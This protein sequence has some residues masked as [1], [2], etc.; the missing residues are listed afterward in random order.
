VTPGFRVVSARA[1]AGLSDSASQEALARDAV[2]QALLEGVTSVTLPAAARTQALEEASAHLGLPL[3]FAGSATLAREGLWPW[4]PARGELPRTALAAGAPADLVVH[5]A[6]LDAT[7][8]PAELHAT[9]ARPKAAWVIARGR[10]CVREKVLLT[11][12]ALALA[13]AAAPH[14]AALWRGLA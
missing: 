11:A 2:A 9:L 5:D 3:D 8:P 4:A 1:P 10:V 6:I 14:R 13:Q 12:D 7:S